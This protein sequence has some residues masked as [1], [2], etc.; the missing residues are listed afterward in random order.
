MASAACAER[1]YGMYRTP[2][3]GGTEAV[4]TVRLPD[5]ICL[6]ENGTGHYGSRETAFSRGTIF[7]SLARYGKP[8]RRLSVLLI[9]CPYRLVQKTEVFAVPLSVRS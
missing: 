5:A 9:L 3:R 8:V 2:Y 7:C 4:S 6:N 1:Y